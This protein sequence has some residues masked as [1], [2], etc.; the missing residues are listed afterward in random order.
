MGLFPILFFLNNFALNL[1]V[2]LYKAIEP[3]V[4]KIAMQIDKKKK[5]EKREK[6]IESKLRVSDDSSK[7]SE[8][9]LEHK[10]LLEESKTSKPQI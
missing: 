10:T 3:L 8:R 6:K 1:F 9:P 4:D 5:K 7:N 2:I